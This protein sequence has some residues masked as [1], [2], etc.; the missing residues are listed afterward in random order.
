MDSRARFLACLEFM[1]DFKLGR[2]EKDEDTK[3]VT[4]RYTK[5]ET[6]EEIRFLLVGVVVAVIERE[7][8]ERVRASKTK[9]HSLPIIP[10]Y[11]PESTSV[12][13]P[14]LVAN[15]CGATQ[16]VGSNYSQ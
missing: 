1:S 15:L 16:N 5:I 2:E 7:N 8:E 13:V 11:N 6:D 3:I 12:T 10:D 14:A 4:R 9:P